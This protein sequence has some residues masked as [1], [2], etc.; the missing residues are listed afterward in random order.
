MG[1]IYEAV[2]VEAVPVAVSLGV[3]WPQRRWRKNPGTLGIMEFLEPIPPGLP[4]EEFMAEIERRIET[5]SM[6]LI[7]ETAPP[8]IVEEA[9]DRFA[10]GINNHGQTVDSPLRNGGVGALTTRDLPGVGD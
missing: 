2:G 7:E 4:L 3:V 8:H 5:R 9:R 6:E 10:R 1:R